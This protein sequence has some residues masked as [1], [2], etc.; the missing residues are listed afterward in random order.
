MKQAHAQHLE[1]LHA[2]LSQQRNMTVLPV[3]YNALLD[4]PEQEAARV[5]EFLAGKPDLGGMVRTVDPV[6]YRN[7]KAPNELRNLVYPPT[8]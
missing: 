2:W 8:S 5:H 7:R 6:L 1:R 3:S 4:R